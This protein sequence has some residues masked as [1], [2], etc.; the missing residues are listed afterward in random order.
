MEPKS[1]ILIGVT[2]SREVCIQRNVIR[3]HFKSLRLGFR[4]IY[5]LPQSDSLR[6]LTH[7]FK[8]SRIEF[9]ESLVPP[10]RAKPP[11]GRHPRAHVHLIVP[12]SCIAALKEKEKE[13]E[14][15]ANY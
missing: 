9:S 12:S 1:V 4:L 6:E 13:E 15:A 2:L 5:S 8:L 10:F 7:D 14:A 3:Y 11:N